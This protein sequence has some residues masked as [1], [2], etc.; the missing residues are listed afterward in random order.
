MTSIEYLEDM[1]MRLM[2]PAGQ[3]RLTLSGY[4]AHC[5]LALYH[6]HGPGQRYGLSKTLLHEWSRKLV[7]DFI[8]EAKDVCPF[9]SRIFGHHTVL[10]SFV[11]PNY[12]GPHGYTKCISEW[13]FLRAVLDSIF[14]KCRVPS[15]STSN[16]ANVDAVQLEIMWHHKKKKNFNNLII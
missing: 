11:L 7:R 14:D 6:C 1:E 13:L 12:A 2:D 5:G 3:W 15:S 10:L 9:W 16:V 8:L 4:W